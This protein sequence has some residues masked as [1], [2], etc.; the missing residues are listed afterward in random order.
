M[1]QRV[2][3][4][5]PTE[6]E[7][8]D[9]PL[10]V[11]IR[12]KADDPTSSRLVG[13]AAKFTQRIELVDWFGD[14]FFEEID[15]RAFDRTLREN[16]DIRALRNHDSNLVLARGKNKTLRL[17]VDGVGL[18]FDL[19]LNLK[20]TLG[21]DTQADVERGDIDGCSFGFYV[22]AE[23][24]TER[25]GEPP[26]RTLLDIELVEI[27]PAVTFPAYDTTEVAVRTRSR[28]G[29]PSLLWRPAALLAYR[30]RCLELDGESDGSF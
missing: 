5:S 9:L 4:N 2:K 19:D 14:P 21:R 26:V 30:T 7:R 13:Y 8:R 18:N 29:G 11:E 22:I 17:L 10:P 25:K 28:P 23:K 1:L 20:T 15:P 12:A 27:S 24:I 16:Q 3:I 6:P